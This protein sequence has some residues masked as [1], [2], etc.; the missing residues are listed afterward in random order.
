MTGP[1]QCMPTHALTFTKHRQPMFNYYII[2]CLNGISDESLMIECAAQ[3]KDLAKLQWSQSQESIYT[4]L[5]SLS[6]FIKFLLNIFPLKIFIFIWKS[7]DY[8]FLEKVIVLSK[9]FHMTVPLMKCV[10]WQCGTEVTA[11][12]H[13][14]T[15]VGMSH[16]DTKV[17][18][19]GSN[20]TLHCSHITT[21]NL[22][23]LHQ[24]PVDGKHGYFTTKLNISTQ[25]RISF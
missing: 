22:N 18:H 1:R 14:N 25:Y 2:R 7:V 15:T 12:I 6:Y 20:T 16:Y 9:M 19:P 11:N 13:C 3:I 5:L 10:I 4:H 23:F 21:E 24:D 17:Y 8:C